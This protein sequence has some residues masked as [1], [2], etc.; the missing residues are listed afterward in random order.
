MTPRL[1]LRAA[2]LLAPALLLAAVLVPVRADRLHLDNG[3]HIDVDRWWLEGD[4]VVYEADGGTVG[5]ARAMVVRIEAGPA[6]AR[7]QESVPSSGPT[8]S[9]PARRDTDDDVSA[10]RENLRRAQDALEQR[11]FELASSYY[12]T[13]IQDQPE[14]YVARVGYAVS[15]IE[16][17]RDGLALSV[18]L[19]GIS[20]QPDRAELHIL[21]GELRYREER[22][23]DA[24]RCWRRAF[25]L[26]P[27]DK[28]R[29]RILKVERELHTSRYYDFASSSHFNLRYDGS[30][31][32]DLATAV[33]EHLEEQYW[34][35]TESFRHSPGQP[36]TVQLFPEREFREVTRAPDWAG[37]LYDGKIRVPLGGLTRLTTDAKHVL[38]HELTHAVVHSKSRGNA[39]RWLQEG[40]AQM[41]EGKRPLRRDLQ[42]IAKQLNQLPPDQWGSLEFSYPLSLAVCQYLSTRSGFDSLVELVERLGGGAGTDEALREVYGQDYGEICR[43]WGRSLLAEHAR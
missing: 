23:D 21:L 18:V 13:L 11:D 2:R 24:L 29:D 5:I 20:R 31:D 42:S 1:I 27:D 8:P 39:P 22:L 37:G 4:V 14:L 16:L 19:D 15:E 6:P 7:R 9:G 43:D 32:L 34:V 3:G 25:E 12:L 30:V 38:T 17:G 35:V 40:L 33:I 26:D 41:A 10:T 36:I 28:L